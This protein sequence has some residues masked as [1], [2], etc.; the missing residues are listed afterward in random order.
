MFSR[1]GRPPPLDCRTQASPAAPEAAFS[2][3]CTDPRDPCAPQVVGQTLLARFG[4]SGNF[5][6]PLAIASKRLSVVRP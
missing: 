3:A 2:R 6:L 5:F 1:T 4:I